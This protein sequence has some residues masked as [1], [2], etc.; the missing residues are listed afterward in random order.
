MSDVYTATTNTTF[1]PSNA[2]LVFDE[3]LAIRAGKGRVFGLSKAD[4]KVAYSEQFDQWTV[5]TGTTIIVDA[6]DGPLLGV[7]A[8]E[9]VTS[10]AAGSTYILNPFVVSTE[11]TYTASVWAKARTPGVNQRFQF[12]IEGVPGVDVDTTDKWTRYEATITTGAD[13]GKRFVLSNGNDSY[14]SDV[15]FWG[16]QLV[17]GTEALPYTKTE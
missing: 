17:E 7:K 2:K 14:E 11:T 15:Y 13:P 8:A 5:G 10:P 16:A 9:L 1:L 6:I 12:K 4:N 3:R